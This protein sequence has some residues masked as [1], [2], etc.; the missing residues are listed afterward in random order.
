MIVY[1]LFADTDHFEGL[2]P[3]YAAGWD[4]LEVFFWGQRLQGWESPPMRTHGRLHADGSEGTS[5]PRGDYPGLGIGE[6][7][8]SGRAVRQLTT[9]LSEAGQL[10]PVDCPGRDYFAFNVTRVLAGLNERDSVLTRFSDG[11]IMRIR[12]YVFVP[13]I[14]VDAHIFKLTQTKVSP[15]FVSDAFVRR[16]RAGRLVGFHFEEVWRSG[17]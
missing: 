7:A 14:V 13:S 2:L 6:P 5:L 9:Y 10:F 15:V 16:V 8:F 1:R 12:E 11:R 4:A 17:V 3:V